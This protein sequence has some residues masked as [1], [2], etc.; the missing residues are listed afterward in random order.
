MSKTKVKI[1]VVIP[2]FNEEKFLPMCLKSLK[3]Q[4]FSQNYEII[5]VD[6]N[7][8]DQSV[9][10]AKKYGARVIS[11]LK[12][13][14]VFARQ[15]GTLAARG[16]IIV[17]T[18]ADSTY[19]KDWL[20][21]IHSAFEQNANNSDNPN[22]VAVLGPFQYGLKPRW[23]RYYSSLLF[24]TVKFFYDQNDK[25]IYAAA[26]NFAFKKSVWQEIGGYN[27]ALSQGGDED[28]FLKKI[29]IQGQII[30][31]PQNKVQTSSRR[32]HRGLI[33]N[34]L[35]SLMGYYVLDYY[36]FGRFTGKTLVGPWP[37][38]RSIEAP[39]RHW[40]VTVTYVVLFS[41]LSLSFIFGS[42]KVY[43]RDRFVSG[44]KRVYSVSKEGLGDAKDKGK[45]LESKR[46][47][48]SKLQ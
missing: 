44:G 15:S 10:I 20:K 32:L 14:V 37:D 47:H 1:S 17:S 40:L 35:V 28:N 48:H 34:L 31:L 25:V 41:F 46:W 36:L 13:G 23:G 19:S 24:N 4:N 43:A 12:K 42:G 3:A 11:E 45:Q 18:D 26:S 9:K 16:E 22:V 2:V 30:Y 38:Y 7:S 27:L 29:K 39:K 33:Y 6:N 8:T 21:N 5:V